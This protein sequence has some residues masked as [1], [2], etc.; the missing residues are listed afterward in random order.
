MMPAFDDFTVA[1]AE[2]MKSGQYEKLTDYCESGTNL[3][4]FNVYR[5]GYYRSAI[6]TLVSNY[7]AVLALL[8][9]DYFRF[10]AKQYVNEFPPSVGTL[11]GYGGEFASFLAAHNDRARLP[12]LS[13]IA[14]L[15]RAWLNVY[16]AA[17]T[18]PI[19]ADEVA[20]LAGRVGGIDSQQLNLCAATAIV[21]LDYAV[22]LIWQKLKES[23]YL[24]AVIKISKKPEYAL[25]W[26]QNSTVLI[27]SLPSAEF[28]FLT[29]LNAGLNLGKAA[30]I[31]VV[32]DEDF[33]LAE[34]FSKVI[35][36]GLL[37][38][39]QTLRRQD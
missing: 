18:A 31:A 14:R 25:I 24:S 5:N 4:F 1:F 21:S 32:E 19:T 13:D 30:E 12:Y 34:L 26:R 27:R 35:T 10:L 20:A 28:A 15:D 2:F 29:G 23:G 39:P 9:E 33:N 16:F 17:D 37:T 3:E 22:A 8:G 11:V 7:P 6:G 38:T 36:A